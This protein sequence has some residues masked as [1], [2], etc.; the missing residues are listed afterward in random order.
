MEPCYPNFFA[1][2]FGLVQGVPMIYKLKT[3]YFTQP[4]L[5]QISINSLSM[6]NIGKIKS[7]KLHHF[8]YAP[9]ITGDFVNWFGLVVKSFFKD[10]PTN[11]L[12]RLINTN[13]KDSADEQQ[14]QE[15]A[16]PHVSKKRPLTPKT[17]PK[18]YAGTSSAKGN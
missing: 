15:E 17:H 4:L 3:N 10:T 7:F 12:T 11:Y 16:T 5:T 18:S 2:Q 14:R 1:Q 13:F 8:N 9:P 6:T